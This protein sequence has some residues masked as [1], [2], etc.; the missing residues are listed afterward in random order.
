V[1]VYGFI[2]LRDGEVVGVFVRV[3]RAPL[4]SLHHLKHFFIKE[5]VDEI[6]RITIYNFNSFEDI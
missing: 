1:G 3:F 6:G 2:Y 4:H 5:A